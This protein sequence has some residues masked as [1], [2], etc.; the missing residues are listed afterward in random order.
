[1]QW[2]RLPSA[3]SK[4]TKEGTFTVQQ[5]SVGKI[6]VSDEP[7]QFFILPKPHLR[8]CRPLEAQKALIVSVRRHFKTVDKVNLS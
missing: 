6:S 3:I 8:R 4:A 1:M 5:P 7:F 2:L